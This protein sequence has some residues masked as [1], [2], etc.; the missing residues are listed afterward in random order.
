MSF[1]IRTATAEFAVQLLRLATGFDAVDEALAGLIDDLRHS[2][3]EFDEFWQA[4]TARGFTELTNV[5]L[6]PKVGRIE[7]TSLAFDVR[8]APGQQLVVACTD[9]GSQAAL[10]AI[11]SQSDEDEI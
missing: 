2:S 8:S 5:F 3:R 1:A 6:H 10:S 11:V 4:N 7:F 9:A